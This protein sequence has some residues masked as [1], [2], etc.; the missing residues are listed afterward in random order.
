M[1]SLG[2]T[3]H[4]M[5]CGSQVLFPYLS[6]GDQPLANH[7]LTSPEE[8]PRRYPL[9]LSICER[10]GLSQ[11]D[12]VISPSVLYRK[13]YVYS[14]GISETWVKHCEALAR[15]LDLSPRGSELP[16]LIDVGSNDGSLLDAV[17]R[18]AKVR[19]LGVEPQMTFATQ[20]KN[21]A[22]G[23][24]PMFWG[25]SAAR[26]AVDL[27]GRVDYIVAQIVLSHVED[28]EGFMTGIVFALREGGTF[29]FEVP[30]FRHVLEKTLFDVIYH[31]H[32]SYFLAGPLGRLLSKYG[33]GVVRVE[34]LPLHGGSLQVWCRQWAD[35]CEAWQRLI[36]SERNDGLLTHRSAYIGFAQY[37][38]R[39]RESLL[40]RIRERGKVFGLGA[41]AK[42][43]V[44]TNYLG[45]TEADIAYTVDETPAKQ[46]KWIPG[47]RIPIVP[48][49]RLDE[50]AWPNKTG[51][52]FTWNYAE[53]VRRRYPG[54]SYL[55]PHEEALVAQG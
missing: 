12:Q 49:S 40:A 4:C 24:L 44:L 26:E 6:L 43:T 2:R 39:E 1:D 17:G 38:A 25:R 23:V 3:C 28:L 50:D 36:Q 48:R 32:L 29:I 52:I 41:P 34:H 27:M 45:L 13:K 20:K 15:E 42:A 53:E 46:G 30:Y 14:S 51:L 31:E 10:C 11:I 5:L 9:S 18:Q 54:Y 7:L 19:L 33:L 8:N 37:V 35:D 47:S 55:V 21:Y 22:A 16:L